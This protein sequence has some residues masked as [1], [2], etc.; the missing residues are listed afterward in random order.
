MKRAAVSLIALFALCMP[1]VLHTEEVSFPKA[2]EGALS[3]IGDELLKVTLSSCPGSGKVLVPMEV[4]IAEM[5]A[6]TKF[7]V[8]DARHITEEI[9]TALKRQF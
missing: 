4:T 2:A 3:G 5:Q 8:N 6:S 7:T 9:A 1:T